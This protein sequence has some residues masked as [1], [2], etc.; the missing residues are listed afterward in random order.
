MKIHEREDRG[1]IL[2]FLTGQDEVDTAVTLLTQ[3]SVNMKARVQSERVL[4]N[5]GLNREHNC[6]ISFYL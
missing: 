3:H 5:I 6:F 4:V 1:D 2:V